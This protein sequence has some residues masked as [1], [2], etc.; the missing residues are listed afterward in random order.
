MV[1]SYLVNNE[2]GG[3]WCIDNCC[4]SENL[5]YKEIKRKEVK[6]KSQGNASGECI[7]NKNTKYRDAYVIKNRWHRKTSIETLPRP[8]F[9]SLARVITSVGVYLLSTCETQNAKKMFSFLRCKV[10]IL[11]GQCHFVQANVIICTCVYAWGEYYT[12]Y[13]SYQI[14]ILW[15]FPM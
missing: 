10:S 8:G 12:G 1:T 14:M 3:C 5:R 4:A 6:R 11:F 13:R 7:Q 2:V 9:L 15:K